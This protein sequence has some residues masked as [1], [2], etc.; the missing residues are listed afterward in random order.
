M[1]QAK[2]CTEKEMKKLTLT[3][4]N[5]FL[6]V[7]AF[8]QLMPEGSYVG[9]EKIKDYSGS[10]NPKHVWYHLSILTIKG[11][12]VF[13]EQSPV[14]IYKNDTIFSAS[15]GGFYSY[16]GKVIRYGGKIVADLKF[17]SCDYCPQFIKFSPPRIVK[18]EE[19]LQTNVIDTIPVSN[20]PQV[21]EDYSLKFKVMNLEKTKSN[22]IL[23]VDKNIY[24]RQRIL[25]K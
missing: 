17:E 3:I 1:M 15:D 24:R 5:T 8:G 13:L 11:D 4:L 23:L 12:S 7:I 22:E 2:A 6:L 16:K 14:A 19:T 21:F 20:E 18:D 10:E 9:L 25:E